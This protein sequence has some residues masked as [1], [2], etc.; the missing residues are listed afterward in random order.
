MI[1]SGKR[2]VILIVLVSSLALITLGVGITTGLV[3]ATNYNIMNMENF[4]EDNP[5]LPSQIL[6]INGELITE[7]FSDEKRDIVSIKDLPEN[8]IYALV[9]RE[10]SRFFEHNGFS[11]YG[12]SRALVRSVVFGNLQGGSTLT[13]Q[14]AGHLYADRSDISIT[15][16]LKELW[17]AFQLERQLT[18]YEILE[19]YINKMPFGHNTHGV[20]AASQF[21]FDHSAVDNTVAESV[22]LVIQLVSTSGRYSPIRFPDRARRVQST[23]IQQ[24]VDNGYVTQDE[25]DLSMSDYW[26]NRYDWSRD[27]KTT[28]FFEREDRAPWFSEYIR[29][30]LDQMM[31][32]Q[33]DIYRDGYVVHTTLNLDFQ[34]KADELTQKGLNTW[35][36]RYQENIDNRMKIIDDPYIPI[37]DLLSLTMNI[38]SIHIADS[39]EIRRAREL[40][41]ADANP[42]IDMLSMMLG[43]NEIN[44][45]SQFAYQENKRSNQQSTVQSA[46]ITLENETG[47]ILAMVG[48]S[49][50]NRANQFN[51]AVDGELM[52]GSAFKPLYYSAAISSGKYTPATRIPDVPRVFINPDGSSY[53]PMNYRGEWVGSVLLRDAL[54]NS[55]NVP[56]ITVLEGIGFEAAID[57]AARLLGYS[58]PAEIGRRFPRL[59]PL[60]LGVITTSPLRMA[61]AYATF[62]NQGR[63]VTPIA[64]RYVEDRNGNIIMNPEQELREQQQREDLQIM[65]EEEAFIMVQLLQETTNSGTLS[66]LPRYVRGFS[67]VPVGGKTG[68]TQ[69]WSDAWTAGFS[70]RFTTVMWAGFDQ[71]GSTLGVNQTGATATGWIWGEYMAYINSQV[72]VEDFHKPA[73]GIVEVEVCDLSGMIPT[74]A[75]KE[76][77]THTEYFIRGTEPTEYCTL[78]PF[79]ERRNEALTQKYLQDFSTNLVGS[80]GGIELL[81]DPY[82]DSE[83]GF[84]EIDN[85]MIDFLLND[86]FSSGTGDSGNDDDA[87]TWL[88]D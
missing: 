11:I 36:K 85:D 25:A 39:Q 13:Q 72:P 3:V 87:N 15:R 54:A 68:T 76:H 8:L 20:E 70:P 43:M 51:R 37:L 84:D 61:R 35:N 67:R 86:P 34:E 65:S 21:Y 29:I 88:L 69:N 59:Y 33:Q 7:F 23:I 49:E 26:N 52:P 82:A 2:K 16:K 50:F 75:C 27:N 41:M 38:E 66:H 83:S 73:R 6:D 46:M 80:R 60:G 55:M 79:I 74:E 4:G 48:G 77:G 58:D 47:Y 71:R 57:R 56:A 5:S 81:V 28:A 19:T 53:T 14:L 9:T 64:I 40:F 78:H 1:F 42:T 44:S 31:Y 22:M 32:G 10:D 17:W 63:A 24:M 30:Q 12:T 45:L 62:P 18:K